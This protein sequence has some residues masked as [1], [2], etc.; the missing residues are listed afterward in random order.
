MDVETQALLVD[1]V[2]EGGEENQMIRQQILEEVKAKMSRD[3]EE[4][5]FKNEELVQQLNEQ[6]LKFLEAEKVIKEKKQLHNEIMRRG[7][8]FLSEV[9]LGN[10]PPL[11]YVVKNI[12]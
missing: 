2:L 4:Q 7:I 6:R 1:A 3:Q 11:E 5:R 10:A 8:D 12:Y 9:E